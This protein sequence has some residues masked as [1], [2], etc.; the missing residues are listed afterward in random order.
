[1]F[2]KELNGQKAEGGDKH[3]RGVCWFHDEAEGDITDAIIGAR[4]VK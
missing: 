3:R 2:G 4:P 1:M